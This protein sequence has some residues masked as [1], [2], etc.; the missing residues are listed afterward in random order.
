MVDQIC[1]ARTTRVHAAA[2]TTVATTNKTNDQAAAEPAYD[3]AYVR[4]A[5]KAREAEAAVDEA[6]P[7]TSLLKATRRRRGTCEPLRRQFRTRARIGWSLISRRH[8]A[9]AIAAD[10]PGGGPHRLRVQGVRRTCMHRSRW[11]ATSAERLSGSVGR[12]LLPMPG[13]GVRVARSRG[14]YSSSSSS[15][16]SRC[17]SRDPTSA[18]VL[19][20][21]GRRTRTPSALSR[22]KNRRWRHAPLAG[23]SGTGRHVNASSQALARGA[24]LVLPRCG[25]HS[26]WGGCVQAFIVRCVQDCCVG[27]RQRWSLWGTSEIREHAHACIAIGSLIA[28]RGR[29]GSDC[30]GHL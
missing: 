24:L 20:A 21:R 7:E 6:R 12:R 27:E 17:S 19:D 22:A 1:R 5:W 14:G 25:R 4:E 13:V 30:A 2:T 8:A 10:L 3:Y 9:I 16:C 28:E 15:S 23:L 26:K 11:S 18:G 29:R